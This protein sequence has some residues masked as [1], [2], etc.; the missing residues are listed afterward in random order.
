VPAPTAA[1]TCDVGEPCTRC[2]SPDTPIATPDGD[3]AIAM[4][5]VGDLVYSVEHDAIVVVP[6]VKTN[7]HRVGHDHHVVEVVLANGTMLRIS[8][9]H[10]TADGRV[11]GDLVPGERLG[12][13]DVVAVTL[14]PYDR[15]FT[16]DILP[17]TS[18]GFY[19]AGRALIGSTLAPR[20]R[21]GETR[22][23]VDR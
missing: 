17:A 20:V 1:G 10:P 21:K 3:L 9:R 22:G 7:R 14:V 11:F 16:H 19:Y 13:V 5:E 2:A 8:P 18:T 23:T 12:E 15:E 6:V 4:L